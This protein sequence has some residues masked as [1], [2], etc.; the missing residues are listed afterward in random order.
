MTNC[1]YI[2]DYLSIISE[3]DVSVCEEQKKLYKF[4]LHVFQTEKL[5]VDM[6]QAEKY[7]ALQKYFPFSLF[8]WENSVF[9]FTI[10]FTRKTGSFGFPSW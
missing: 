8:T 3:N 10:A 2:D 5:V 4:V 9:S 7:F 6:E 1:K